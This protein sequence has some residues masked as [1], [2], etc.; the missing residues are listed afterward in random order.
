MLVCACVRACVLCNMLYEN[1][2]SM[3]VIIVVIM[4]VIIVVTMTVIV[5]I[6]LQVMYA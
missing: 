5:S 1:Y 4:T 3:T 2:S 6:N